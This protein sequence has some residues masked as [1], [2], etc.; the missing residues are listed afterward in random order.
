MSDGKAEDSL[1]AAR[2]RIQAELL[3]LQDASEER[4]F[5]FI[6][7]A[8]A[9]TTGSRFA[10]FGFLDEGES[11][12]DIHAWSRETMASCAVA[13]APFHFPVEEAGIWAD[14]VRSRVPVLIQDYPSFAGKRGYPAGHVPIRNFLSIP[15]L[16]GDRIVAVAAVANKEG[17][18]DEEDVTALRTLSARIWGIAHRKRAEAELRES[19]EKYRAL[20]EKATDCV[21][22]HSMGADGKP[23]TLVDVNDAACRCLGYTR[24]ELIELELREF[25]D[26]A[27][28]EDHMPNTLGS[29]RSRG[30]AVFET[31]LVTKDGDR[32]P[33]EI[34][35]REL[36]L[37]GKPYLLAVARDIRDRKKIEALLR[38]QGDLGVALLRL[39]NRAP[40][41]SDKELYD[42]ALDSAVEITGS[43][44]GFFHLVS[45]SQEEVV[46]TSWNAEALQGCSVSGD[47]HYLIER[48]GNWV[49]CLRERK[50]VV[51][52]DFGSS[53]N[54]RGLPEGHV[55][56]RRFM[57]IPVLEGE[58][59][60][61]IFGV[62]NKGD[63]YDDNDVTSIQL[64]ANELQKI[65]AQRRAD[66]KLRD[67]LGRLAQKEKLSI[68]GQLAGRVGHELRS[69]LAV[70]TSALSLIGMEARGRSEK[71]RE[72][73]DVMR[74]EI[75]NAE[76]ILADLLDFARTKAPQPRSIRAS[77]LV[78]LA[79]GRCSVPP[80]IDIRVDAPE[81]LPPLFV[82]PF[83][84]CQVL[85]N[86]ITN[87]AQAMPKG[88]VLAIS[89]RLA[90]GPG[91]AIAIS[92]SDTGIG[93]PRENIGKLFQPLFTTKD[94]GVGLGLA[95]C[96][97][98]AESNGGGIEARSEVGVGTTFTVTLPTGAA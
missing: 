66:E 39:Y 9:R 31:T 8:L 38:R 89:A 23:E 2:W 28:M 32:V 84:A 56:I 54:R 92:V 12:M 24:E 79:L 78:A 30:Y 73:L 65:L 41:L 27:S 44:I 72:Y 46:L 74:R 37:R 53:P 85:Q 42:C 15:V 25:E 10:F 77:E 62:G 70:M 64:V 98:L 93:I 82:D 80:E 50:P 90:E 96:K 5:D 35:T 52:N 7:D 68:L 63:A 87:G 20:F 16:D 21:F 47:S 61:Y 45:E 43:A 94:R 6:V 1:E 40:K 69:P 48:A 58:R 95:I 67:A 4:L 57:S 81:G 76:R 51:Y 71:E 97:D 55:P 75:D 34:S 59:V 49:D 86:L 19:E 17:N 18:F 14:C 11:R 88:G 33:V 83:Q 3:E 26:Q 91:G 13:G 22:I 29:L 36:H 60:A